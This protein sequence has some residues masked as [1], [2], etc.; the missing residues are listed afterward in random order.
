MLVRASAIFLHWSYAPFYRWPWTLTSPSLVYD[1]GRPIEA[2]LLAANPATDECRIL[3]L[4]V[5]SSWLIFDV[6]VAR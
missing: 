2:K 4:M 1:T 5:V 3:R 6:L